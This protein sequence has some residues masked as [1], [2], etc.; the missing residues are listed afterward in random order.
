MPYLHVTQYFTYMKKES[1]YL[2][3]LFKS[4]EMLL[5]Q[6][7]VIAT[8]CI[9]FNLSFLACFL[10]SPSKTHFTCKS[11]L[12]YF[13]PIEFRERAPIVTLLLSPLFR[14][15]TSSNFPFFCSSVLS[16]K[17]LTHSTIPNCS[18]I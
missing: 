11:N 13:W 6:Y 5:K 7:L 1:S 14:S 3:S 8:Y 9:Y 10:M 17:K 4:I 18:R 12:I 2:C 16:T 15:T